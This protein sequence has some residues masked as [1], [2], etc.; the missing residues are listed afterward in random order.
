MITRTIVVAFAATTSLAVA[1]CGAGKSPSSSA[2]PS[3]KGPDAATKKALLQYAQCMREHGVDM[4]DPNFSGGRVTMSAGGP[5]ATR[6]PQG[7]MQRAQS[8]CKQYQAKIKPPAMSSADKEKFKKAA[9]A[10]AQCMRAHGI[11]N[12]PDPTFD[13]NGGAQISIGKK[14]GIDPNDPKFQAAA[15]ACQKVGGIGGGPSTTSVGGS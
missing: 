4:K 6:I 2:G 9:L 11:T 10:N 5:G 8:A 15:K 12:F 3:T 13:N 7:T 1:A 14:A